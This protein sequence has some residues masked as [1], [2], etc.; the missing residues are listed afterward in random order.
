MLLAV[1]DLEVARAHVYKSIQGRDEKRLKI[2][3]SAGFRV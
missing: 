1:G 2:L 3:K